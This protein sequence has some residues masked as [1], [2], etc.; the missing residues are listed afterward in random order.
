MQRLT[1]FSPISCTFLVQTLGHFQRYSTFCPR[2]HRKL[3]SKVAYL[4]R[5]GLFSQP[6]R[7]PQTAKNWIFILEMHLK[8][9][10]VSNL[11]YISPA[12]R[13]KKTYHSCL[14]QNFCKEN[15]QIVITYLFFSS[16]TTTCTFSPF[17]SVE[18][19]H[20]HCSSSSFSENHAKFAQ[21]IF[22]WYVKYNVL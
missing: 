14:H 3:A 20:I 18:I 21:C 12:S 1:F 9:H 2:K 17:S 22:S 15:S 5:Y 19:A 13:H 11:C 10:L 6:I 8:I 16:K 4:W 7:L